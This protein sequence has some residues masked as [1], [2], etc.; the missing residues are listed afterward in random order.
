MQNQI[1]E[2]T[3]EYV[4]CISPAGIHRMAYWQWGNPDNDKV[5]LCVHGLTRT[6]RDFD[7]LAQALQHEYRVVCP[8]IV[9]RGKSDWLSDPNNY[10]V[11]QYI[12]DIVCLL[13]KLSPATLDYVGTSMGGL[14]GMG[15][16]GLLAARTSPG[17]K[18]N[19]FGLGTTASIPLHNMVFND[20]G[21]ALD[22]SGLG[23]IIEYVGED[24]QFDSYAQA[25][26]YVKSTSLGFG[27]HDEA[28]W[29]EL[30]KYVFNEKDHKYIKHYD[31]R[32]AQPFSLQTPE[33]TKSA[34]VLLWQAWQNLPARALILRGANSDILSTATARQMLATNNHAQ[35]VEFAGVGH[36]PTIRSDD[37]IQ[38][39]ADFLLNRNAS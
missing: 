2:P 13:A 31:L 23:R 36:A 12:A 28:G 24:K 10:V 11:P 32:L 7:L 16:A 1:I 38:A 34:E 9:G 33:L 21:P 5:L 3:L 35:L 4:S 19:E 29:S 14:I 22:L 25:V 30:T 8:D 37:Q 26:A 18:Q 17:I 20:I 15:L 27:P 39:V 6:G